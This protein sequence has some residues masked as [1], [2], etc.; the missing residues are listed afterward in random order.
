MGGAGVIPAGLAQG[1]A[2]SLRSLD[3]TYHSAQHNTGGTEEAGGVASSA[4]GFP[5][6]SLPSRSTADSQ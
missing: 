2:H 3:G 4:P 5:D 1:P 6:L